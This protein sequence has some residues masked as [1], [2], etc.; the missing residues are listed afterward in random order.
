LLPALCRRVTIRR[1]KDTEVE[2]TNL[3]GG[4]FRRGIVST[5]DLSVEASPAQRL[6]APTILSGISLLLM[7]LQSATGLFM[8]GMYARDTVWA[9]AV[10]LG[11]DIVNLF[12]FAP[13]LTL[14]L[15]ALKRGTDKGKVFW[16]GVQAPITYDYIYYP[17]GVAGPARQSPGH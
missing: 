1:V 17:L 5:L 11:N 12:L 14:A 9:R 16:L 8:P 2:A 13:L 6:R 10:F 4:S 15:V 3:Y 7:I